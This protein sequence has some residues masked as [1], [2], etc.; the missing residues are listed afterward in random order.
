[1]PNPMALGK[2]KRRDQLGLPGEDWDDGTHQQS[3]DLQ[4][5]F[6]KHFEATFRPLEGMTVLKQVEPLSPTSVAG[7]D[8]T[9]DWQGLSEEDN[10]GPEVIEH[11]PP[12]VFTEDFRDEELKAF[13]VLIKP[14]CSWA[15][16]L[17]GDAT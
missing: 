11:G 15:E 3:P 16:C 17:L 7:S 9:S 14:L 8:D 10:A 2:R 1:M 13:M 4:M 6:Q 5:L 12:G